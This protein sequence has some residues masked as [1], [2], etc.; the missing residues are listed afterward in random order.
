MTKDGS[1]PRMWGT[2][3]L[4]YIRPEEIRFIPTHVGNTKHLPFKVRSK[5]VHPHA[6]GEHSFSHRLSFCPNG[7]SPRMWGTLLGDDITHHLGRFI[8]THVG[9]TT[10]DGREWVFPPVHPHAC[11]EHIHIH[12]QEG[13]HC[14]SS[15]RMWG[16]RVSR[17]PHH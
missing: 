16:T 1:S 6:C 11:G 2:L 14:G 5:P 9:N 7:S 13:C 8:P 12:D 3:N 15:P 17:Y 10:I 4:C